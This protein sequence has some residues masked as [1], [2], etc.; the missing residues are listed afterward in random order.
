[1]GKTQGR[2]ETYIYPLPLEIFHGNINRKS[3][4][5]P[6]TKDPI[7]PHRTKSNPTPTLAPACDHRVSHMIHRP[8]H[9]FH[10]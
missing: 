10:D 3:T 7:E 5:H 1:M 8:P 6:T 9:G 2:G 4:N